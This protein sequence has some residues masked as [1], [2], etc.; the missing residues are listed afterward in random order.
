MENRR[1]KVCR[2]NI[3]VGEVVRTRYIYNKIFNQFLNTEE[4]KLNI[5]YYRS[6]RSILF[7]PTEEKLADDLLY[8]SPNY[9]I[10]NIS[11]DERCMDFDDKI[12]IIKDAF[13]ISELLKYYGYNEE[14]TYEDIIE[15]RKTFFSKKF[16]Y[17][18]IELFGYKILK[19]EEMTFYKHGIEITDPKKIKKR[20]SYYKQQQLLGDVKLVNTGTNILPQ[21][22]CRILNERRDCTI[23]ELYGGYNEKL[24][25]FAPHKHEV[26][27]RKLIK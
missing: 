3:H 20:I 13:N 11:D 10:L 18:N 27:V 7:V 8:N 16:I 2:D 4:D 21:E 5:G 15:I 6:Y 23:W 14:L 19:P 26:K 22:Y 24:D 9:P 1:Y 25:A 12:T 17:D